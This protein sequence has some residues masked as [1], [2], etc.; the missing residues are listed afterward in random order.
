[1]PNL[2]TLPARSSPPPHLPERTVKLFRD[3]NFHSQSPERPEL[4]FRRLSVPTNTKMHSQ[5]EPLDRS[6]G[7][8]RGRGAPVFVGIVVAA[9]LAFHGVTYPAHAGE[10]LLSDTNQFLAINA[11]NG[12]KHGAELRLGNAC[13]PDNP[14][15][16]WIYSRG[17]LL[18]ARDQNL[19]INAWNGAQPGT[20]LRLH[21]ACKPDNPDCTW[22]YT[23]SPPVLQRKSALNR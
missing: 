10:L 23:P 9:T 17:E 21:N 7:V 15:C 8:S 4:S 3:S 11:W 19:A 18:S 2:T 13:K 5:Q 6:G 12:A 20:E 1:M 14:D 16:I 22:T